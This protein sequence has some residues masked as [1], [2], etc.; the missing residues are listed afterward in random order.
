MK[1]TL[2]ILIVFSVFNV[3]NVGEAFAQE[4]KQFSPEQFKHH[5]EGFV[6]H[7]A[8][9]TED[10]AVKFFP[11]LE[12]MMQE[13]REVKRQQFQLM[14][15]GR[16]AKTESDYQNLVMKSRELEVKNAKIEETYY[17]K[18]HSVLSWQKIHKVSMALKRFQMDAL[19]QFSPQE[20][21]GERSSQG[22][23]SRASEARRE[24]GA[25]RR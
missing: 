24:Q 6:K 1:K 2:F 7:E 22:A 12:K 23:G 3:F 8:G 9:L 11:L 20:R 13:Q 10:E 21:K 14:G 17:K 25:G 18:F 5:M 4:K 16:S 15:Q 19:K